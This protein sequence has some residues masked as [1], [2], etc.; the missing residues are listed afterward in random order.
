M[1]ESFAELMQ[2]RFFTNALLAATLASIACGIIG[3]YI[4]SRRI[5]FISGGITHASFGG[6]GIGYY[7]GFNPILGA[8]VFAVIS[9][10]GIEMIS[11]K[12]GVRED[13]LIGILWSLGMATGIIFVFMSP[14]YAP[15][16]MGYLFGSILTVSGN[17]VF[18]MAILAVV[19]ILFFILFYK[20]ILFIA[21]DQEYAKTHNYPVQLMN[22]ILIT[23]VALTIVMSIRVA[24]VILVLSLLTIPQTTA[25]I[26][27]RDFRTMIFWS[28]VFAFAGSITGLLV[29]FQLDIP[30]GASIIFSLILLFLAV[31][32]SGWTLSRVRLMKQMNGKLPHQRLADKKR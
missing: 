19:I 32:I 28:V 22:C 7:Y 25:N 1:I 12:T 11:K 3:T 24:G 21:F 14:G 2:Y 5:V 31:R 26:L 9:A 27:T 4:V 17:D 6:I 13:S 8:A 20:P 10:L 16:L 18:Q 15:D 30:S 29:S 23:L